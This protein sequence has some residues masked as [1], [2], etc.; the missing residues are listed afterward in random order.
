M[1]TVVIGDVHGRYAWNLIVEKEENT[2]EFVFLGDYFDSF[3]ISC[4]E[5]MYNFK[6]IME[7]KQKHG[8]VICLIGNH[9]AHYI[10][11]SGITRCSG[12][13]VENAYR[14][15]DLIG[16]YEN[17][18]QMAYCSHNAL[19]T[20]AGVSPDFIE[21]VSSECELPLESFTT[22]HLSDWLNKVWRVKPRLFDF[23][24]N[25]RPVS[26]YGDNVDQSP[27][28][29]RPE[30]LW[31]SNINNNVV[32]IHGHTGIT[33]DSDYYKTKCQPYIDVSVPLDNVGG[34]KHFNMDRLHIYQYMVIEDNHATVRV[35][36]YKK[37]I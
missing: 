21:R 12:Y 25:H 33:K 26:D 10:R 30:S 34:A 24:T 4:A 32:Q 13:Q 28:W 29:I 9:D 7:F 17:K 35:L 11:S 22:T 19:F 6:D 15:A 8:N 1:K 36:D 2:D 3:T 37:K 16:Q 31:V 5:Q 18:L 20:H 27:I 23:E 14:I